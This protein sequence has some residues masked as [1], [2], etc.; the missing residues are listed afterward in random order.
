M[1]FARTL[2]SASLVTL[3]A[4]THAQSTS[5]R[6]LETATAAPRREHAIQADLG[7]AVVGLAYENVMSRH[8]ALQVEGHVFGTWFWPIFSGLPNFTGGGIQTR[9]SVFLLGDAPNGVYLAAFARFDVVGAQARDQSHGLGFGGSVGGFAGWSFAIADRYN[10]RVGAGVQYM[11][12]EV[13]TATSRVV[14]RTVYPAIDLVLGYR[15]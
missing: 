14:A 4:L 5:S 8:L 15:W 9:L 10:L 13:P 7:L 12:Y 2:L 3:P 6:S 1:H 11:D